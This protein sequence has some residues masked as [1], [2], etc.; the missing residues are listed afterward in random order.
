MHGN[1]LLAT[2]WGPIFR[3]LIWSALT[4]LSSDHAA[5]RGLA[6]LRFSIADGNLKLAASKSIPLPERVKQI[7]NP[8]GTT[9]Q[10]PS[11]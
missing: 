11:R 6:P 3:D 1:S 2:R 10:N 8:P 9:R 5:E 7:F 4:R